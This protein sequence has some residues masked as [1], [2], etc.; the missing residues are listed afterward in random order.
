[1]IAFR[2]RVGES[3]FRWV[4]VENNFLAWTRG[5]KA[6]VLIN[7]AGETWR[8]QLRGNLTPGLYRDLLDPS[9]VVRVGPN[10]RVDVSLEGREGAMFVFEGDRLN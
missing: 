7:K 6:F 9:R 1:M 5:D 2:K 10:R 4:K 8:G 3:R